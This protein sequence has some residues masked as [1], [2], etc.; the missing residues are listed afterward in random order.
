MTKF[1]LKNAAVYLF[2]VQYINVLFPLLGPLFGAGDDTGIFKA[3]AQF[4]VIGAVGGAFHSTLFEL[5]KKNPALALAFAGGTIG[6]YVVGAYIYTELFNVKDIDC[7][8]VSVFTFFL[9]I[10]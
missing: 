3:G 1:D 9:P 2:P 10:R 5:L 6:A 4:A 8:K 7:K